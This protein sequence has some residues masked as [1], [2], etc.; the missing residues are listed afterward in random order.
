MSEIHGYLIQTV[1][2]LIGKL[3]LS[4]VFN[5]RL[6][7]QSGTMEILYTYEIQICE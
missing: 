7:P 3:T 1:W 2:S 5:I 4:L 6:K